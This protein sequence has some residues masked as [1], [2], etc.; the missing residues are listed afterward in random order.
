MCKFWYYIWPSPFFSPFQA[1]KEFST[2]EWRLASKQSPIE[3][4]ADS[5]AQIAP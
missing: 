3:R 4:L 1:D 5:R 2:L